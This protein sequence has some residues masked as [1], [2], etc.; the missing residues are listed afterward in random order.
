MDGILSKR[1]TFTVRGLDCAEEIAVLKKEVGPVVGGETH[2]SFNLM[3]GSM[4][5]LPEAGEI[6]TDAVLQAVAR[7]GMQA[8]IRREEP[9]IIS[10][11]GFWPRYGRPAL[12]GMS[13]FCLL[14][15]VLHHAASA[16]SFLIALGVAGNLS[17]G[18]V[19]LGAKALYVFGVLSGSWFVLPKVWR[20]V[21]SLRPDMNLLMS[22]ALLGAMGIG[23]WLEAATVSFLFALSLALESWSVGHA[24]RAVT[25]LLDLAPP[26]AR[27]RQED[28][29]EVHVA[30]DR[31]SVG[32]VFIVKPGERIPL[33]GTVLRGSGEANQA[34]ITGESVPIPKNTGD[35]VFA[36]T[37]NG[38]GALEI[39]CTK[40]EGDT[41]LA[42]II[43]M[44]DESYGRR[45]PSEQWVERF[46]RIYTPLI[47]A[48]AAVTVLVPPLLAGAPWA[49]WIYRSLVLLVIGCPCA[50]VISTPVSIVAALA[51]AAR[52]GVLVKGGLYLE[53]PARLKAVALDKT[54]TL[55]SGKPVV[56]EVIPFAGH[57]EGILLERVAA[58]E[59]RSGHPLGQA[60]LDYARARGVSFTPVEDFKLL[61][62]KGATARFGGNPYWVGSRRYLEERGQETEEVHRRLEELAGAGRTVVVAGTDAHVCGLIVM[63][64]AERPEARQAVRDL[65]AAGVSA[66][67]ML[68][69][70]NP[71]T[72]A[73]VG[74]AV[75]IDEIRAGLLP[76]D[77]VAAVETLVARHG[78]V[79][80]VGDGVNDA[81]ALAR[82]SVGIA[83]GAIGSDAAI[84][85]ADI[86][87][88]SGDLSR[89]PWLVHHS[90]R[91]LSVIRQ[92][93]VFALSV[94]AVFMALTY[95]GLASLW[96]A[97]AAD[98][99]AS[100][101]V[102]L[103]GLR[104]LTP[105][106]SRNTMS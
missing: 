12:T 62:G 98:M 95:F 90:R 64:D 35:A 6:S 41:I 80:M 29:S 78:I 54:G 68:T 18:G 92:N 5:V 50:L 16:G 75:G 19:P 43:R 93:V 46:A 84:E 21:R 15:G 22:I 26:T 103:N 28:G 104:L 60:I 73:A 24:R 10:S 72:A 96:G 30:P 13:G 88:M 11:G 85:T 1:L 14:A 102:V 17:P 9:G 20:A 52:N 3:T 55:T 106:T 70:D 63:A 99:G 45:A 23:A 59:S 32:T 4:T 76:A 61:P 2:L 69:G 89:L 33:D 39:E 38:N 66:I 71:G 48:A 83:M 87:L 100:L 37:I 44:V 53:L 40:P 34:P 8:E 57:D 7:T 47:M 51:S 58:M 67:V 91:T 101:A 42:H 79:A 86:A 27:L 56:V 31:V 74:R 25:A 36:G 65:R 77:K 82:A 105:H 49:P 94:K 97:I 81:P